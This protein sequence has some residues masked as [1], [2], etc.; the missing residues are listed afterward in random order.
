MSQATTVSVKRPQR[1][2]TPFG[3]FMTDAAVAQ[4]LQLAPFSQ[5]DAS[6][7]PDAISLPQVLR[8]DTRLVHYEPGE[9]ILREG[10]YGH[11]AFFIVDGSIQV[12]LKNLPQHLLGRAQPQAQSW[13]SS[14][15]RW[16]NASPYPEVRAASALRHRQT[17]HNL[18]H[19]PIFLQDVPAMLGPENTATMG[20]GEIFGELAALTRTPRSATVI[21]ATK[22]TL[23]E[24]R[25]QGLRDILRYAPAWKQHIDELYR[26]NSLRVH[27]R[28]TPFLTK[29]SPEALQQ[30]A[31]ATEFITYGNFD[32]QHG[33]M[34]SEQEDPQIRI[35]KEPLIAVEGEYPQGLLLIRNGFARLSKQY[36]QGHK[37]LAY[38][39]KGDAFG[40][41]E[42]IRNYQNPQVA[43]WEY[44]LRA[45]GY[46]DI[47]R[48]P[49]P[50]VE[51]YIAPTWTTRELANLLPTVL[52]TSAENKPQ[53]GKIFTST[54]NEVP[55][56]LLEFLVDHRY[57]NGTAAM[58][59]DLD[60]CTRCDDCVR[61]CAATHD[62]NPRFNRSGEKH[63]RWMI[64]HACMHCVDPVC[65]IGCPT[66]AIGRDQATGLVIIN[67]QT[68]IG[69][70]TCANSCPYSNISMVA[71]RNSSG[72]F[73]TDS[74]TQLPIL[75]A[76]KC[77][78]C[79]GQSGGPACVNACPH[80][81]MQRVDLHQV[82]N[83]IHR[84]TPA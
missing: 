6:R 44:S 60:K 79:I 4:L 70:S 42:L 3:E 75:K 27:L 62:N 76:T 50:V 67:D 9:V 66:G 68:C 63:E 8:N 81:A 72:V 83:L 10:D 21:A 58:V 38:L 61:A 40:V 69:C 47:L 28:E 71:T 37:T 32:W 5:M 14:L 57:V 29:L 16:W 13:L 36:D 25:W 64:A 34:K 45:V 56:G 17:P 49:T 26:K 78:L 24:I 20:Q 54:E 77:D 52:L 11:S 73:F 74:E 59:I 1:W 22:T 46:V 2:E 43:G 31:E 33:F 65:M 18:P 41:Q 15:A 51:K 12:L 55:T 30:V 84:M 82:E 35:Q 53:N 7:F 80:N 23:L 48:I 19:E 39:G